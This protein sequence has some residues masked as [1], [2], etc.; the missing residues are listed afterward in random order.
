MVKEKMQSQVCLAVPSRRHSS[1]GLPMQR[2][3]EASNKLLFAGQY[4]KMNDKKAWTEWRG[5]SA[6]KHKG[7]NIQPYS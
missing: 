7:K 3:A 6:R 2:H 1:S 4:S 5:R